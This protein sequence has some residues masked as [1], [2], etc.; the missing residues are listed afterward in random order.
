MTPSVVFMGSA[1]HEVPVLQFSMLNAP[2]EPHWP[3]FPFTQATCPAL[4][5]DCSVRVAKRALKDFARA[6]LLAAT[7]GETVA[8]A[9][10]MEDSIVGTPTLGVPVTLRV[11][12]D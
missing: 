6:R 2:S 4:Q 5:A 12:D 7:S 10:G 11:D 1:K 3:M 9:A 8:V